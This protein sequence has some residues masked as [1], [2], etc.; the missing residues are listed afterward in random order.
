M[1]AERL[2]APETGT[3]LKKGMMFRSSA[4]SNDRRCAKKTKKKK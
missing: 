3:R 4:L 2:G 1:S